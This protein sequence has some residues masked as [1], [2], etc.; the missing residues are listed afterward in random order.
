MKFKYL[1]I[2]FCIIIFII[3]SVIV[4]LPII[5]AN[6]D[7][8]AFSANIRFL[9]LPLIFFVVLLL[10]CVC[11]YFF[12]NYRLFSLLEREDWPALAYYLENKIYVKGKFSA[13]NV[14]LLAS[15]YLIISDF[16]SVF[17]LEGKTQLAKPV[18][19]SRNA[20]IFGSARILGGNYPEAAMFFKNNIDKCKP[21]DKQWVRWFY[22]FAELLSCAFLA[23][24]SEFSS[25]AVSSDSAL[26][27]GLSA[28]FLN[29]TLEKKSS[30]PVKCREISETGKTRV[31]ESVKNLKNWNKEVHKMGTDIHTA[32]IRKYIDEVRQW[33]FA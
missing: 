14:R 31:I 28:Y 8:Y 12:L 15:S 3:I 33:V 25:L 29:S 21:S 32:I 10:V 19:I 24:E 4:L 13:Q 27:T 2:I 1:V 17:K 16:Q 6:G 26:I 9:I 18:E 30:E 5:S 22:G 20:L 11:T 7:Y 23:A